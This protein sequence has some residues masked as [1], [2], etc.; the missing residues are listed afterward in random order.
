MK[1]KLNCR[2][3]TTL[4][5]QSLDRDL[6]WHERLA[7]RLHMIVCAACPEFSRQTQFLRESMGRWKRY[8][9]RD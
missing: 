9:E 4:M 3:V 7:V 5:L 2:E 1:L 6:S 8:S